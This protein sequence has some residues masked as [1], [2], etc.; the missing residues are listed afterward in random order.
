MF[1][2]GIGVSP[3]QLASWAVFVFIS[4]GLLVCN[5]LDKILWLCSE[6]ANL[7]VW[8]LMNSFVGEVIKDS[9]NKEK[10]S[11]VVCM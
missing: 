2:F 8:V 1:D 6:N 3:V 9:L 10:K 5:L 7:Q 11:M 4:L